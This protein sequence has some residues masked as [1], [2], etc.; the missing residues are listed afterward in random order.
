MFRKLTVICTCL[1]CFMGAAVSQAVNWTYL[2][3]QEGTLYGPCTA[4]FDR[5]SVS[6]DQKKISAWILWTMDE[7]YLSRGVHKILYHQEMFKDAA[8]W[9]RARLEMHRFGQQDR[10]L[11]RYRDY[12]ATFY[13]VTPDSPEANALEKIQ[14]A[15][16]ERP[17]PTAVATASLKVPAPQWRQAAVLP[18][19]TLYIDKTTLTIWPE[20]PFNRAEVTAK[21][22][23]ND[24]ALAQRKQEL[25]AFNL[26]QYP[27]DY[28]DIKYTVF[29]YH[30]QAAD[31]LCRIYEITDYDASDQRCTLLDGVKLHKLAAGSRDA[32]VLAAIKNADGLPAATSTKKADALPTVTPVKK[33]DVLLAVTPAKNVDVLP[34]K[35]IYGIPWGITRTAVG[36]LAQAKNWEK[37]PKGFYASSSLNYNVTFAGYPAKLSC[38]FRE[39][40]KTGY[41]FFYQARITVDGK[42][43]PIEKLYAQIQSQLIEQYGDTP[44]LGYPPLR[45]SRDEKPWGPGAG[46]V[47]QVTTPAGQIFE[48]QTQLN[49]SDR[50][51]LLIYRN[52]SVE[53][54]YKN[55]INPLP[56]GDPLQAAGTLKG[57]E[58][59]AWGSTTEQ[60]KKGMAKRG[61]TLIK[62]TGSPLNNQQSLTF[63]KSV[64][65]GYPVESISSYFK[66]NQFYLS[67]I[68]VRVPAQANS[69]AMYQAIRK[70]LTGKYGPDHPEKDFRGRQIYVWE[71]P[72]AG[73]KPTQIFLHRDRDLIM[74]G[75]LN[76][77]LEARLNNL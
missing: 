49:L 52:L 16:K 38:N 19:G 61:F 22:V 11:N 41:S 43:A 47:W 14:L 71:F 18:E 73:F 10:V 27:L 66:H 15:A 60:F 9:Q 20:Q 23:W 26:K 64:L 50:V 12:K 46:K 62:E 44:E 7:P 39:D 31:D 30:F 32:A 17:F 69:E 76:P 8:G 57:Y 3:R 28:K 33:A 68:N 48:V 2:Q 4:Y 40:Y 35:K 24:Q 45:N 13:K 21:L 75:Y 29:T 58:G 37:L 42:T 36:N 56:P 63:G 51:L 55:L 59:I 53:R 1:L 6:R 77:A 25:A 70:H 34:A 65:A 74:V 5:D 72:L 67:S 54:Y